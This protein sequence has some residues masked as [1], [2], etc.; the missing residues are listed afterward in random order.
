MRTCEIC[1]EKIPVFEE[2]VFVEPSKFDG[3]GV[4]IQ[5][6][7]YSYFCSKECASAFFKPEPPIRRL[8]KSRMWSE[9]EEKFLLENY[10]K[11]LAEELSRRLGKTKM[12]VYKKASQLGLVRRKKKSR[13]LSSPHS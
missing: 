13:A 9:N 7:K 5:R 12:S 8:R 6:P 2:Y 1:Q 10:N 3:E 11:L 4:E